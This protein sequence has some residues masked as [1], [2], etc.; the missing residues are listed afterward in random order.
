[1]KSEGKRIVQYAG[2]AV[3]LEL[4]D[5][6]AEEI[7][8]AIIYPFSSRATIDPS[9]FFRIEINKEPDQAFL[10]FLDGKR[11]YKS[12]NKIDFAEMLLSKVCYQ[13]AFDSQDGMLFHAAG[14]GFDDKGILVPGGIGFGK[15]TF[16][17]WMVTQGCD[18]F[19]DEF[20]YFPW[21]T[22]DIHSF[23]RPLHLKKPSREVLAQS[24]DYDADNDLIM[25]GSHSDLIHPK[26]IRPANRYYQPAVQLILFPHYQADC[27]LE[28]QELTSGQTGLEL[29]QYL[30]N[31][32]NLPAHGFEEIARLAR[33][34]KAIKFTY[35][36]FQQ[37]EKPIQELFKHVL[38][39]A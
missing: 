18:Y 32:R 19:S 31:A 24:I 28:W 7:L 22:D 5:P 33:K 21:Q 3:S 1:M 20:V 26:L 25:V 10:L 13:L 6:A 36:S 30:I 15:S 8:D 4:D 38:L 12:K 2:N 11:I 17:A 16:T 9:S 35:S 27:E 23:Y 14:L 39:D 34:T 37:I 29:M